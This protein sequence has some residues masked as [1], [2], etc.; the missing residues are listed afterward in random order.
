PGRVLDGGLGQPVA[1]HAGEGGL[2]D[3]LAH[4]VGHALSTLQGQVA[5]LWPAKRSLRVFLE[6]LPTEVFGTSS[7]NTTSSGSHH[8]ATRGVRNS[9]TSSLVSVSPGAQTTHASGRSTQRSWATPMTAASAILGWAMS[10]F[11]SSTELIHSPPD[12]TRSLVRST[13]R[14]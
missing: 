3:P 12:F 11:S 4:V 1:G 6:N 2:E 8:L 9:M 13:R 5:S 10:S 14:M 7:M